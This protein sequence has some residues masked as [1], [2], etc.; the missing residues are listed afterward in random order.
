M[1]RVAILQKSNPEAANREDVKQVT[2]DIDTYAALAGF[3][4]SEAGGILIGAL[5]SEL[6][7][8]VGEIA[9]GFRTLPESELRAL[10]AKIDARLTFLQSL[11]RARSNLE[12][13]EEALKELTS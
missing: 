7:N 10:G 6:A 4:S 8:A 12:F 9:R 3:A 13:A 2:G 1:K 11:N 5:T